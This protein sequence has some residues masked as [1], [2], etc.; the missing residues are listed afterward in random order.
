MVHIHEC[1]HCLVRLLLM[2]GWM[3]TEFAHVQTCLKKNRS[4][5]VHVSY[6]YMELSGIM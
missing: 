6:W 2:I 4:V 3:S 1:F 5:H